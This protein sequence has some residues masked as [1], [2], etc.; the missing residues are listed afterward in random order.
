MEREQ[1]RE[2]TRDDVSF[3]SINS[4]NTAEALGIV[5]RQATRTMVVVYILRAFSGRPAPSFSLSIRLSREG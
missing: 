3:H 5:T 4:I 2:K 1:T